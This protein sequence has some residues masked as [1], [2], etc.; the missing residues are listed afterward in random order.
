M[1]TDN[2]SEEMILQHIREARLKKSTTTYVIRI[3]DG[4]VIFQKAETVAV[5]R[6]DVCHVEKS[7]ARR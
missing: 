2:Q 1:F 7:S 6:H 3:V 5:Q 4:I